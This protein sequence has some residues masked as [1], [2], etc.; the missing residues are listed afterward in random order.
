MEQL[1]KPATALMDR[2]RYS[3]KFGFIF[4]LVFIPLLV[5]SYLLI[6]NIN[7][8][9]HFFENERNGLAYIK[10]VRPLVEHMP[11]HRGMTNAYL[12]GDKSFHD[13]ILAKRKDVDTHLA[14]LIEVN[15]QFK[16]SL[17]HGDQIKQ[18]ESQWQAM[19]NGSMNM[20]GPDSFAAHTKM[21]ADVLKLIVH[22]ADAAEITLDPKLDTY[23][24]GDAL[25]NKLPLLAET[26]GQARGLGAGIA[27][28][29]AIS[30]KQA[31]R[32]ALLADRIN[33]NNN[34]LAAGLESA[35]EFNP[36]VAAELS[37]LISNNSD[38]IHKFESI[39]Q[40]ELLNKDDINIAGSAVFGAGTTAIKHAFE[41][42]D[43]ALPMMDGIIAK[44]IDDDIQTEIVAIAVV[45]GVLLA[46]AYLFTG[47]FYSVNH[48]VQQIGSAAKAMAAGDLTARA[49]L[50]SKDEMQ[51]IASSF[52]AMGDK[53]EELIRTIIGSANQLASAAEEVSA[54]SQ[55]TSGNIAQQSSE[56]DQVATAMNQMTATV[57]EVASNAGNAAEAANAANTEAQSGLNV[58]HSASSTIEQLASEVDNAATVIQGL[59]Q[60]TDNIGGILS[61]IKD[62]ADQ[63]NLLALNA[64]IEA[65]RAGEQGR[66]FA[67]VADEVRTLAARTQES[68]AEIESMISKLQSG[69]SNA[70][71]TMTQG[72]NTAK[73]SVEQAQQAATALEAITTAVAT[74][75]DMNTM[76]ASAAEEQSATAEEMNKNIVNIHS[77]AQ[78]NATGAAQTTSASEEL[79][80]L[81][82][83]LQQLVGQFKINS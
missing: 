32:L 54:V 21:I 39:L 75:S 45:A 15:Q 6:S 80:Q 59:Q 16:D 72:T 63:T 57:T 24:L 70:V 55:E 77:L 46:I 7:D 65:A 33:L 4:A 67:V 48:G 82:A 60:D 76:I 23:Y 34:N 12:N 2:F 5:L 41:L 53:I 19:K 26:M 56:T 62:I 13:R 1:F 17:D 61:V 66:G 64:A 10:A 25:V 20:Q 50:N 73:Q 8:E 37:E 74:I 38:S 40:D 58:V 68:T 51:Q 27:A 43:K 71:N 69:A 28:N 47:L 49:K 83:Q 30:S 14:A 52:N 81:A 29:H 42:F 18:I 11:Q 22:V 78:N 9:I 31:V 36:D 44:R 35:M 79:A 3:I